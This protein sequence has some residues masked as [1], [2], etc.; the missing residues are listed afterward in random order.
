MM[1]AAVL[2]IVQDVEEFVSCQVPSLGQNGYPVCSPELDSTLFKIFCRWEVRAGQNLCLGDVGGYDPGPGEQ[3]FRERLDRVIFDQLISA[4]GDHHRIE[5]DVGDFVLIQQ[6]ADTL[7]D[8]NAVQHSE[9]DRIGADII[10][11]G[12]YL[13]FEGCDRDRMNIGDAD[14]I[15]SSDCGDC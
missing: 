10:E 13:R 9:F 8:F 7:D 4:G 11:N 3:V 5:H 14:R 12:T 15:L 6:S 1:C 2:V